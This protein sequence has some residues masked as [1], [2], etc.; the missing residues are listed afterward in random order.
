MMP[1]SEFFPEEVPSFLPSFVLPTAGPPLESA[2][3]TPTRA[4]ARSDAKGAPQKARSLWTPRSRLAEVDSGERLTLWICANEMAI[5]DHEYNSHTENQRWRAVGGAVEAVRGVRAV[6][7]VGG[8]GAGGAGG[9]GGIT[10]SDA[11]GGGG[12]KRIAGG[13]PPGYR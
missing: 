11:W 2:C 13:S 7:A 10:S 12:E 8:G 6:G 3:M 5:L 9:A 4:C 1:V